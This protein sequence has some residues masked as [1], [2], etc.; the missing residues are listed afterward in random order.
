MVN[1]L[2]A[3]SFPRNGVDRLTDRAQ[4][5]INSVDGP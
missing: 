2:E 3:L 1:C 5:D 4:N